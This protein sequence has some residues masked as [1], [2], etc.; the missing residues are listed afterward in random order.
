MENMGVLLQTVDMGWGLYE[1]FSLIGQNVVS[2]GRNLD[3]LLFD[4]HAIQT[5]FIHEIEAR[6]HFLLRRFADQ[7]RA[8]GSLFPVFQRN[9]Q[10]N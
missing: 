5:T 2:I 4:V 9:V 6:G 7:T 8:V 10:R 1:A 3:D